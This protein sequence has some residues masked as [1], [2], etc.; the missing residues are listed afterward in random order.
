MECYAQLV[1]VHS[2]KQCEHTTVITTLQ[3]EKQNI[4]ITEAFLIL[5]TII[6]CSH[7]KLNPTWSSFT[8]D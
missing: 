5:I 2:S 7:P 4:T 6:P 8:I 1:S 3:M